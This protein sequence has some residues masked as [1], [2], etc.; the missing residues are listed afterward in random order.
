MTGATLL[1]KL[2][3]SHT[4]LL[5]TQSS[6]LLA[7]HYTQLTPLSTNDKH[8]RLLQQIPTCARPKTLL[9][10]ILGHKRLAL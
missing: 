6:C 1:L 4:Q 2:G 5:S 3:D 7:V 8:M 9:Q 10:S